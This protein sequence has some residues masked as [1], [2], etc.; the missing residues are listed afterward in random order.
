M[1]TVEAPPD[2]QLMEGAQSDFALSKA[3]SPALIAGR[4]YGK[5]IAFA[6]KAYA[7]VAENP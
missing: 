6:A 2:V 1:V 7:Y 3:F 5:T 4:G